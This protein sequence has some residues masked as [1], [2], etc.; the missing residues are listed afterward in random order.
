M[1]SF[2]RLFDCDDRMSAILSAAL[3]LSIIVSAVFEIRC[4]LRGR[5]HFAS[6][7]VAAGFATV[8]LA[9]I[10]T[11]GEGFPKP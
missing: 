11:T 5:Q 2:D 9:F 3:C 4:R 7:L 8:W 1:V 6:P 10:I